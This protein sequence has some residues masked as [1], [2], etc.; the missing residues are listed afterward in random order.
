MSCGLEIQTSGYFSDIVF[1][2]SSKSEECNMER[3]SLIQVSTLRRSLGSAISVCI[4]GAKPGVE[5]WDLVLGVSGALGVDF[6]HANPS[7]AT[8]PRCMRYFGF[9]PR[10]HHKLAP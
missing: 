7:I 3:V 5:A 1:R 2:F 10:P 6:W 4:F 9:K 8:K